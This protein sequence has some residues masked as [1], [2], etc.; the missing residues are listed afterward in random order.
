MTKKVKICPSCGTEN[1]SDAKYCKSCSGEISEIEVE[2]KIEGGEK[3]PLKLGKEKV[4]EVKE[5]FIKMKTP[6]EG[7][8]TPTAGV[9]KAEEKE[10]NVFLKMGGITAWILGAAGFFL[11]QGIGEFSLT[12][13][14]L[15]CGF[16]ELVAFGVGIACTATGSSKKDNGAVMI[17]VIVIV[18]AILTM[19]MFVAL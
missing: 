7:G 19:L 10:V 5:K 12:S 17:G 11:L 18:L 16:L 2:E 13:I 1:P 14:K 4:E 15:L 6:A 8:V 3:M 9:V